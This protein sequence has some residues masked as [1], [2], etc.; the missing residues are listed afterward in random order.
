MAKIYKSAEGKRNSR[1]SH[2]PNRNILTEPQLD[3]LDQFKNQS[4]HDYKTKTPEYS[5]RSFIQD[6]K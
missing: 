5:K 2:F 6:G 4:M 3:T 1:N